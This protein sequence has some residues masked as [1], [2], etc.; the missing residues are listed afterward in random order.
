MTLTILVKLP[1]S[2]TFVTRF[3][4][5]E[6]LDSK[7]LIPNEILVMLVLESVFTVKLILVGTKVTFSGSI[8]TKLGV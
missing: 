5:A 7:L 3:I 2:V 4:T 8:M 6:P 1:F